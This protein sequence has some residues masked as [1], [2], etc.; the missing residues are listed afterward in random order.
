MEMRGFDL[1]EREQ[2]SSSTQTTKVKICKYHSNPKTAEIDYRQRE[3]KPWIPKNS[4]F[5]KK[6]KKT[7]LKAA[8]QWA[9]V[10]HQS[11]EKK[12]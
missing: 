11:G 10:N 4:V 8:G 3:Q 6:K 12:K 2:A 1:T 9:V 5:G 7:C